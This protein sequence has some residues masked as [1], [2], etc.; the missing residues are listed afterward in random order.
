MQKPALLDL[1]AQAVLIHGGQY[2]TGSTAIQNTL[3][4]QRGGLEAL[5][6][7][8]PAAGLVHQEKTGHRHRELMVELRS[9]EPTGLPGW[10]A[11]RQELASWPGRTVLSHENFF[12]PQIDP[13][14]VREQLPN[15]DLYLLVYLRHPVDYLDSCYREWVRRWKFQG[16]LRAYYE[17]RRD[18]LDVEALL[19]RWE[20]A[21]GGGHVRLRSYDRQQLIGGC[22]V[23]DFLTQLGLADLKPPR[24]AGNESLNSRQTL[25]HLIAN[26]RHIAPRQ[27]KALSLR[28]AHANRSAQTLAAFHD[29][30]T[31]FKTAPGEC[32]RRLRSRLDSWRR[33]R[34]GFDPAARIIDDE[35]AAEIEAKYLPGYQRALARAGEPGSE[36]GPAHYREQRRDE[37]FDSTELRA[38]VEL[39]LQ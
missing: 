33:L 7:C 37:G 21:T 2:K 26:Q 4:A 35:L 29:F 5:G 6:W 25:L 19:D 20:T 39:L 13:L 15:A 31:D 38:A 1:P 30:A 32:W 34:R 9:G 18:W 23:Q 22:V 36:L 12:S 3:Y 8:Y 28:L 16:T 24:L 10:A 11:L 17:A 27:R 14:R